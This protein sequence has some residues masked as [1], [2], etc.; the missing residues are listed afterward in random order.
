MSADTTRERTEIA[1]SNVTSTNARAKCPTLG[2]QWAFARETAKLQQIA[3]AGHRLT[4]SRRST[5]KS[6]STGNTI[7]SR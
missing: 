1:A 2:Q 4:P 6:K 3:T 7:V 5:R